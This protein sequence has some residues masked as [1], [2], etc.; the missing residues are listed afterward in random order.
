M[1]IYIALNRALIWTV[2]GWGA[3]PK[4]NASKELPKL[5]VP[6]Y[7]PRHTT[8]KTLNPKPQNP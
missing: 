5:V 3:V 1:I 7:V 6:L 8:P 2:T 4:V